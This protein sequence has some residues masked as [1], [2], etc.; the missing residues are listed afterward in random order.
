MRVE[1]VNNFLKQN[2]FNRLSLGVQSLND[3]RLQYPF[4]DITAVN[5]IGND[6]LFVTGGTAQNS[7]VIN[8]GNPGDGLLF[9]LIKFTNEYKR[10]CSTLFLL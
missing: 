7:L 2:G 5:M 3:Q 10:S 8:N 6:G 4:E 1:H 9:D